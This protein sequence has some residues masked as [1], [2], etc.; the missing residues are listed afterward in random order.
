M[1]IDHPIPCTSSDN[2]TIT[3]LSGGA[4]WKGTWLNI[5]DYDSISIVAKSDVDGTAYMDFYDPLDDTITPDADTTPD[6][7][8]GFVVEAG[9]PEPPHQLSVA[10][11]WYRSRYLNGAAAQS[12]LQFITRIGNKTQVVAPANISMAQNADATVVRNISQAM[13][14]SEGK[15]RG[16]LTFRK[17]G[18]HDDVDAADT[19]VAYGMTTAY[20][21]FPTA[22]PENFEVLSSSTDDVNTTGTGAWSV[23]IQYLDDDYAIQTVDVNLNGTTG[24]DSGVSGM[25]VLRVTVLTSASSNTVFNLGVLTVRWI[26]TTATVFA[27]IEVGMNITENCIMT[28][29]AGYKGYLT[30]WDAEMERGANATGF[31]GIYL[32]PFGQSPQLLY[33]T[34]LNQSNGITKPFRT[35][36]DEYDEKTDVAVRVSEISTTNVTFTAEMDFILV[37]Q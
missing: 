30:H 19:D 11:K 17:F 10:R 35:F 1:R 23:R 33:E 4:T 5:E 31:C 24:V 37:K 20:T 9:I 22:A 8:L 2:S 18:H 26:T 36:Y 25:R 7:S 3:P 12:S 15:R 16:I 32:R 28:I 34:S 14:I 13:D 21:G 27:N 29:P 6:S